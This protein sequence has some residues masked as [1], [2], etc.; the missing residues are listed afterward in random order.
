MQ[1]QR[2]HVDW[3]ASFMV[4]ASGACETV[5]TMSSCRTRMTRAG[6][7]GATTRQLDRARSCVL[8]GFAGNGNESHGEGSDKAAVAGG[9]TCHDG[10]AIGCLACIQER[11][12]AGDPAE[13]LQGS[14][15]WCGCSKGAKRIVANANYAGRGNSTRMGGP[16]QQQEEERMGT[17]AELAMSTRC[18]RRATGCAGRATSECF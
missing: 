5:Q 6:G 8:V 10:H 14:L 3:L 4:V 16:Q 12:S 15:A 1:R 13:W 11:A 2:K 18:P 9:K 7:P 17:T